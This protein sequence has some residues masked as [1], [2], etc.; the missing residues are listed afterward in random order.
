[1]SDGHVLWRM[2]PCWQPLM[3][4]RLPSWSTDKLRSGL[5]NIPEPRR[6]QMDLN[7]RCDYACYCNNSVII[8][9]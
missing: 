6:L 9:Y 5:I 3:P 2:E 4:S 8:D 1:M 7:K